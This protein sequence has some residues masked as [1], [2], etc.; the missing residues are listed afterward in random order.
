VLERIGLLLLLLWLFSLR[1]PSAPL[2]VSWPLLTKLLNPFSLVRAATLTSCIRAF[3]SKRCG[4]FP[5]LYGLIHQTRTITTMPRTTD[6]NMPPQSFTKG[7]DDSHSAADF[8]NNSSYN[9]TFPAAT[10]AVGSL[11]LAPFGH[12]TVTEVRPHTG[13]VKVALSSWKLASENSTVICYLNLAEIRVLSAKSLNN[14]SVMEQCRFT[15]TL[16]TVACELYNDHRYG[17]ALELFTWA[18]EICTSLLQI[19]D[20]SSLPKNERA[21]LLVNTVKNSNHV[22]QCCV[23]LELW[24]R[25][26]QAA[27][28]AIALLDALGRKQQQQT[29]GA[30]ATGLMPLPS[31]D[32]S[33]NGS[34]ASDPSKPPSPAVLAMIG[35]ARLFGECRVKAYLIMAQASHGLGQDKR[36]LA[37]LD[38]AQ[39]IVKKY[40]TPDMAKQR[41]MRTLVKH[42]LS[43]Q[44][45]IK[46]LR[47]TIQESS[48]VSKVSAAPKIISPSPSEEAHE[49]G[50]RVWFFG[51]KKPIKV[52]TVTEDG[53]PELGTSAS[54]EDVAPLLGSRSLDGKSSSASAI[55]KPYQPW[56]A[57]SPFTYLAYTTLIATGVVGTMVVTRYLMKGKKAGA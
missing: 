44:K 17:A 39:A 8:S 37:Q 57:S 3:F 20:S 21:D 40:A 2:L 42:F 10:A 25:A 33:E 51:E 27:E 11:I 32:E 30:T 53:Y 31:H 4:F 14:M 5:S 26:K 7:G 34:T 55:Q 13:Q 47:R 38:E 45:K 54:A 18:V 28:S 43:Y 49:R 6:E 29:P 35:Q 23:Q 24:Q 22:G 56:F 36:A 48:S 15:Q 12:G 16:K 41:D 52:E 19:D 9:G 1:R 50:R 46:K